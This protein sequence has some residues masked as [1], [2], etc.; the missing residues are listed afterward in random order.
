MVA[1]LKRRIDLNADVGEMDA[2]DDAALMPY[3]SSANIA[4]GFHAGSPLRMRETVALCKAHGVAVGAHPAYWD[5]AHFGRRELDIPADEIREL[6]R[7]QIGALQAVAAAQG[8]RVGHVKPHGALYNRSA[9]D[10]VVADAIADA[11]ASVDAGL[12]LVGLAG[13]ES[14]AAGRRA[15]LRVAAEGFADRRYTAQARL[16][17]RSSPDACIESTDE[18]VAQVLGMLSD[19]RVRASSGEDVA[20]SVDT[21]CLHGDGP[22]ALAFARAL[23]SRLEGE[24]VEISAERP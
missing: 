16:V 5:R 3:L 11:V 13:S 21:V 19:G 18:A 7:Y 12:V 17:P 10:A 9:R 1:G 8:V 15:G 4:C 22:S 14:L 6:V 24:G 20:L 2:A 23:R